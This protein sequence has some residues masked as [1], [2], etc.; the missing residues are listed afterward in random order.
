VETLER[1]G[2]IVVSGNNPADVEEVIKLIERL[3]ELGSGADVGIRL[4]PLEFGD[5]SSVSAILTQLYQR[6]V[7][8]DPYGNQ[9]GPLTL[10]MT[11]PLP[12]TGQ[13]GPA[14]QRFASVTLLAVP[15]LNAILVAA[16]QSRMQDIVKEI[17]GLDRPSSTQ[18]R[19]TPFP[20]KNASAARVAA[21]LRNFYAQRYPNETSAL[22]QVRVT[23]D[24]SSNTVF[25]Q[26][27]P[28]D[29]AEIRDL[30]WRV[31]NAVSNAVNDLRVVY[32]RN[33]LADELA[34]LLNRAVSEG[35]VVPG[36]LGAAGGA[37][38]PAPATAPGRT[39]TTKTTSL[40]FISSAPGKPGTAVESGLLEDVHILPDLRTNSLIISAPP[41]SMELLL[42]VVHEMDAVPSTAMAINIFPLK[43]A[44]AGAMA[45]LLQQ[46]MFGTGGTAG[47]PGTASVVGA[48]GANIPSAAARGAPRPVQLSLGGTPPEGAPLIELRI[49]TDPRTNS[50]IVA[51]SRS[52]LEVATAI[53][54]RLEDSDVESRPCTLNARSRTRTRTPTIARSPWAS[55]TR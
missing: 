50:V 24:E 3:Q 43:K 4:V 41:R 1:L 48:L 15:R 22:D 42:A 19:P 8:V 33:A 10:P 37:A 20:L 46:L 55:P 38:P 29:L 54:S 16:P 14:T 21:M 49:T 17:K 23:L 7:V 40:R 25:V 36:P 12:L 47:Q 32:L 35:V 26:A 44:D 18:S 39:A 51:G 9:R 13:Q 31:D 34:T 28:T 27:A 52:D 6:V 30:I 5:A 11:P 53:I 45:G 2:I